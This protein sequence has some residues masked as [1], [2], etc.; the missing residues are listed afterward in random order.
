M[1]RLCPVMV[2]IY[3]SCPSTK[4]RFLVISIFSLKTQYKIPLVHISRQGL[5]HS[6]ARSIHTS[7]HCVYFID[8]LLTKIH[9]I[10]KKPFRTNLTF[11]RRNA[12]YAEAIASIV[13]RNDLQPSQCQYISRNNLKN[14]QDGHHD[15]LGSRLYFL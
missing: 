8:C 6:P 15:I 12:R 14:P 9:L 10:K 1:I 11:R 5:Q 7:G 2:L 3:F 13:R 4:Y